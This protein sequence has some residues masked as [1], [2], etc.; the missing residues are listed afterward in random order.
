MAVG[1]DG[2]YP[3]D[4]RIWDW[5]ATGQQYMGACRLKPFRKPA[6]W[7]KLRAG[8]TGDYIWLKRVFS[9]ARRANHVA[10]Y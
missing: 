7:A 9:D 8:V 10:P 2:T 5:F 3:T 1:A 6:P 4:P